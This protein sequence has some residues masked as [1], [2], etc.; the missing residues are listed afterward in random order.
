MTRVAGRWARRACLALS[1][2]FFGAGPSA[3]AD[4]VLTGTV[5]RVADG[6]SCFVDVGKPTLLEVR[7]EGIDS[8]ESAWPGH[9]AAQPFSAQAKAFA[10]RKLV[11]RKV[12][13][14]LDEERD[15]YGRRVG[16]IFVDGQAISPQLVRA[17]LAWWNP[18]YAPNDPSLQRLQDEAR[19][20]R[21]GL[22]SDPQPVPPWVHREKYKR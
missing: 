22:W 7:I 19:A 3:W 18:R 6:D 21:R 1:F 5:R 8:P 10:E 15:R 2:F 12:R 16:E 20:A 17:G 14:Q 11:G 9:W 13:L 4:Q